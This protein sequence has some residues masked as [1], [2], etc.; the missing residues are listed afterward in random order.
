MDLKLK[1]AR[2]AHFALRSDLRFASLRE[3]PA[4]GSFGPK[5]L[6]LSGLIPQ[7][8]PELLPLLNFSHE[9][10]LEILFNTNFQNVKR[11]TERISFLLG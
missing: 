9:A 5:D 4:A 2:P 10:G 3:E 11:V 1:K 7:V 8:D 6:Y